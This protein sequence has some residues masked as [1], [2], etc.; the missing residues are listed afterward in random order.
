M[1]RIISVIFFL[2]VFCLAEAAGSF[3]IDNRYNVIEI[4]PERATGLN[5]I[6]VIREAGKYSASFQADNSTENVKWYRY[7]N[8]GGGFAEEITDIVFD[9]S[10]STCSTLEGDMGYI[11]ECGTDRYYYWIVDYSRHVFD[12]SQVSTGSEPDCFSNTLEV[13]GDARPIH[14]FSINGKQYTLSREI[15][16]KYNTLEWDEENKNYKQ[17]EATKTIES[18]DKTIVISPPAY[19][20][21]VF[22]VTGDRF[23]KEW[24]AAVSFSTPQIDCMAVECHTVA[25]QNENEE[26]KSNQINGGS[27]GLGGSAP[28]EINFLA[29]TTDAVIHNEWQIASDMDFENIIYRFNQQDL[30]YTFR[31]EGTF[32]VRFIGSNSDGSCE[33]FGETYTVEIGS[34]ELKCPNAFSPGAS[35]GINDEWKVSYRSIV[36]FECWIFDR[37]GVEMFHFD[38]PSKGWDGKYKGK[39]VK[40]GVYYYVIKAKGADGKKYKK[41]GDINILRFKGRPGSGGSVTE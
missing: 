5:K 31:E 33:A 40:P 17:T 32:Y 7:S 26:D 23:L 11:I 29:Y 38:D 18:F 24:N 34:S 12:I 2:S 21:T 37:Y 28:A 3:T 14:Y 39:L 15:E 6:F 10:L 1:N 41:S 9:G 22:T 25:E 13:T 35:E 16:I 27:S 8:L 30:N 36:E 20:P 4:Q 19:C